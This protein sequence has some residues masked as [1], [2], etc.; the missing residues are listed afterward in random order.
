MQRY[1]KEYGIDGHPIKDLTT[2]EVFSKPEVIK[3]LNQQD[4][5]IQSM[6]MVM[7]QLIMEK[8][9]VRRARKLLQDN[10]LMGSPLRK[11]IQDDT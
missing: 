7:K 5:L 3:L 8:E 6:A 10:D 11:A 4:M 1:E 2:G 9:A